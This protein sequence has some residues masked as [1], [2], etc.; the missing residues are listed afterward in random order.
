MAATP[1]QVPSDEEIGAAVAEAARYGDLDDLKEFTAAYG[2]KHIHY[3][4]STQNT[5]LHFG[6]LSEVGPAYDDDGGMVMVDIALLVYGV[7]SMC[8]WPYPMCEVAS[9]KWGPI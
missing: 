7:Y 6:M 8:E 9:G 1:T 4:D 3:K 5:G 2:I